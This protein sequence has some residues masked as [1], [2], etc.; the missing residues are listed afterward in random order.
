MR[1]QDERSSFTRKVISNGEYVI[2][3]PGAYKSRLGVK[4]IT[5]PIC[6]PGTLTEWQKYTASLISGNDKIYLVG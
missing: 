1:I 2:L 5:S 4:W 3:V 6:T